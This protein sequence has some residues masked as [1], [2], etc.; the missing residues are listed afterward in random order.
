MKAIN[1]YTAEQ[2][3][4]ILQVRKAYVYDLIYTGRLK[5]IRLSKRRFRITE[6]ALRDFLQQEED[7]HA[8]YIRVSGFSQPREVDCQ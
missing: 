7:A 2:V 4:K 1:V 5:A 6:A 8:E 3:S